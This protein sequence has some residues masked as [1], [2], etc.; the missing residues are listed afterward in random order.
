MEHTIAAIATGQSAAAIGIVRLS[1][2]ECFAVIDKIFT[3]MDKRKITQRES[4]TLALGWITDPK[5]GERV[6][7]VLV[8]VM[9]GPNSYTGEDVCEI[10]CHGGLYVMRRILQICLENG[11]HLAQPGEFS[12]RAFLNGKIDLTQAEGIIDLID[13]GTR[14]SSM[15]ALSQVEGHIGRAIKNLREELIEKLAFIL[16]NIE[17]PEEEDLQEPTEAQIL[18]DLE[19]IGGR[20]QSLY[21]SYEQGRILKDGVS[22]AIVGSPNVGKSSILNVLAG[23]ERAIVTDIEGTTRDI[24]TEQIN[25]GNIRL[26]ISDT[27]G[28]RTSGDTVERIGVEKAIQQI[29]RSELVLFV[30]DGARPLQENDYV[31]MERLKEKRVICLINKSDLRKTIDES[32]I[33]SN[34]K[35]VVYFSA[36]TSTGYE[37]LT[38][39]VEEMFACSSQDVW[40]S[41]I[42]ASARQRNGVHHAILALQQ[43]KGGLEGGFGADIVTIDLQNAI[44]ALG[45]ITGEKASEDVLREIFSRFCLGK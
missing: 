30:V 1:G 29:E 11:A 6:D 44:D 37:A 22:T 32:Y 23:Y 19:N 38:K 14:A 24:L 17:Y 42:L 27:A 18:K 25:L 7:Q 31:I 34:F 3:A 41:E 43:A 39:T 5:T 15:A 36:A 2:E 8:S 21:D 10:N 45:E 12:K 33:L 26:N 4:H 40:Q 35:H 20:L 28:I 13:S 16:V 9:R